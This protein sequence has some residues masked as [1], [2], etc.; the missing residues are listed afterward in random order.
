MVFLLLVVSE[1]GSPKYGSKREYSHF[2]STWHEKCSICRQDHVLE[3][4]EQRGSHRRTGGP[5]SRVHGGRRHCREGSQ[6]KVIV[7]SMSR[8]QT[9]SPAERV[10]NQAFTCYE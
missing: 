10:S 7:E 1:S 6:K 4:V 2:Q 8:E 5:A 3:T 9:D